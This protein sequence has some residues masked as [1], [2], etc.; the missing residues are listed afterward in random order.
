MCLQG[1]TVIGA[2]YISPDIFEQATQERNQPRTQGNT[3]TRSPLRNYPGAGWSR[4]SQILDA[5]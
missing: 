4:G 5:K 1:I 3:F 2:R